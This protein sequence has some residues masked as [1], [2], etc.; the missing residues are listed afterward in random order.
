[1]L[2]TR[3]ALLENLLEITNQNVRLLTVYVLYKLRLY[4]APFQKQPKIRFR[5]GNISI[6]VSPTYMALHVLLQHKYVGECIILVQ[7]CFT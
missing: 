1:M 4:I 6:Y 5:H 7:M 2:R 3:D